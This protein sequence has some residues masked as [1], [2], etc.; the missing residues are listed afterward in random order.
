MS[1]FAKYRRFDMSDFIETEED[2]VDYLNNA[3]NE[4]D[5]SFL[6]HALGVIAK[7][8]GMTEISKKSGLSREALYKALREGAEPRFS[9]IASV[10]SALGFKISLNRV[11]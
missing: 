1:K 3:L 11:S 8:K 10:L 6:A 2:V 9:T 5:V 7:S 4:N